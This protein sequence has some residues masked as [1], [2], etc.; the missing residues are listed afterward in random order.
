[1]KWCYV[2]ELGPGE[3][4]DWGR[5]IGGNIPTGGI[6]PDIEDT[7]IYVK[8][9][10]LAMDGEYD[11]DIIDVDAYGLKVSG[12]DLRRIIE[13]CYR[14]KPKMLRDPIISKYLKYADRLPPDK[15]V[16]LV[17]VAI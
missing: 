14:S 12:A 17:A 15:F 9:L 8:I 3:K 16:A 10:N 7:Y 13:D 11:G 6:L 2:G 1:M 5:S 4:L